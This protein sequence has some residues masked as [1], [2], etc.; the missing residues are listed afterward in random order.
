MPPNIL[1]DFT[2]KKAIGWARFGQF[3]RAEKLFTKA[4]QTAEAASLHEFVF[5]IERIKAG[6]QG[7]PTDAAT[8][9]DL[10]ATQ[11]EVDAVREVSDSLA[12][13]ES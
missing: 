3:E 4:L 12:R 8:P 11:P 1:V 7:C 5:R 2:L 9:C 10:D 6:L 13:L